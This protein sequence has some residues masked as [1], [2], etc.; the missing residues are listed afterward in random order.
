MHLLPSWFPLILLHSVMGPQLSHK[1]CFYQA[2]QKCHS[3][4]SSIMTKMPKL[5]ATSNMIDRSLLLPCITL[6]LLCCYFLLTFLS[7]C[8]LLVLLVF[9]TSLLNPRLLYVP[10]YPVSP[11]GCLISVEFSRSKPELWIPNAYQPVPALFSRSQRTA[12]LSGNRSSRHPGVH[13]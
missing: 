10:F 13:P 12:V 4:Q 2:H 6:S 7:L 9:P 5:M 8:F 1:K 3:A 11:L